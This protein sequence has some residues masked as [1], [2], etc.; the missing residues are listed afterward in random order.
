MRFGSFRVYITG[1]CP[2][3]GL[4]SALEVKTQSPGQFI[5]QFVNMTCDIVFKDCPWRKVN[6][7]F[8]DFHLFSLSEA[9]S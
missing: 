4:A 2:N 8:S 9:M 1:G 7:G 6:L 5:C 3:L